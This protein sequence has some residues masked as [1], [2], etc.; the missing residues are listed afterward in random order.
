M[1]VRYSVPDLA[2]E[3]FKCARGRWLTRSE[4]AAQIGT[5]AKAV[6]HWVN[7]Y[8]AH[9]VLVGRKR[10]KNSDRNATHDGNLVRGFAPMEYTLAPAWMNGSRL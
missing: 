8:E 3:L 10:A 4:I 5:H 2:C 9:G 7:R 6:R 1:T